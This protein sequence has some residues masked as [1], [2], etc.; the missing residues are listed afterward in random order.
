MTKRIDVLKRITVVRPIRRIFE[1]S[2]HRHTVRSY[3]PYILGPS[4]AY[5][6]THQPSADTFS[7]QPQCFVAAEYLRIVA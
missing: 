3:G 4:V 1:L 2:F 6:F 5:L 7:D